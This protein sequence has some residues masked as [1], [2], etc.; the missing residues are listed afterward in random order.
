MRIFLDLEADINVLVIINFRLFMICQGSNKMQ[1]CLN[2]VDNRKCFELR[3]KFKSVYNKITIYLHLCRIF[4]ETISLK[5]T[6]GIVRVIN[7]N[8]RISSKI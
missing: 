4:T 1:R 5:K 3:S 2:S 7:N 8:F 6:N